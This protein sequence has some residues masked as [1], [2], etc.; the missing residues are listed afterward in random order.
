MVLTI[1]PMLEKSAQATVVP[2]TGT[3]V[4]ELNTALTILQTAQHTISITALLPSFCSEFTNQCRVRCEKC[5]KFFRSFDRSNN[6]VCVF[7]QFPV[8]TSSSYGGNGGYDTVEKMSN[9]QKINNKPPISPL[10]G[11]SAKT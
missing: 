8:C 6:Y 4:A 10:I 7:T 1:T 11:K 2:F 9:Q 5:T 3:T